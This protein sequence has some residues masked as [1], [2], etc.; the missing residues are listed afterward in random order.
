VHRRLTSI[1]AATVLLALSAGAVSADALVADGDGLDPVVGGRLNLGTICHAET[2]TAVALVAV[3]AT[4]H[5]NNRQ[6]FDNG[7]TVTMTATILSGAGLSATSASPTL[8]MAADWRDQPNQT[9]SAPV[10]WDVSVTP[11]TLG[12]YRGQLEFMAEGLNRRGETITRLARLNVVARVV[13]CAPPVLSDVSADLVLEATGPD[14]ADAAY[15][16][17]TATDAVD[18]P[19]AV[20]CDVP[21]PTRLPLGVTVVTCAATDAAGNAASAAF[22]VTVQDTTAAT[23]DAVPV[24][25]V[26][27][28][29]DASGIAVDWAELTASDLVDGPLT[30]TCDTAPGSLFAVGSTTVTCTVTDA[31]G[32]AA[33]ATF[34]VEV[35]APP[36]PEPLP[37]DPAPTD[38]PAPA[39]AETEPEPVVPVRE[40]TASGGSAPPA[41]AMP[42]TS[43]AASDA[44]LP[45]AIG[46][47]VL[48]LAVVALS[49][50]R[51]PAYP[52][53]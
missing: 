39:P 31:A 49:L 2:T 40:G 34:T 19:V 51:R 12:R 53:R 15:T 42:N 27:S 23:F 26:V 28:A 6:V 16:P 47:I 29:D 18:G 24:D 48:G 9:L 52:D 14:G 45:M 38:P 32:N 36:D 5:P 3:R 30:A 43:V 11:D 13:D 8:V 20:A 46:V 35:V 50:R 17:P 7:A 10:T 22:N 37:D 4:G 1:L 21:S 41:V 44:D 33:T 25:L